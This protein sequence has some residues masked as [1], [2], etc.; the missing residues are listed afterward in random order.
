MRPTRK[1]QAATAGAAAATVIVLGAVWLGAGDP[2]TGLEGAL[3]T[4]LAFTFGW[5]R[6][7]GG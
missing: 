2:P 4:V 5:W 7:D 6:S 3:A 1:V